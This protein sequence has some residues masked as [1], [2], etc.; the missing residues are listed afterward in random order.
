M[1]T[2]ILA[3]LLAVLMCVSLLAAC[4]DK[5]EATQTSGKESTTPVE[6]DPVIENVDTYRVLM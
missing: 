4:G 2:R 6:K 1:K 3:L 5:K